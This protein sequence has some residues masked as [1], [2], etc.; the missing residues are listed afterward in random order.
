MTYSRGWRFGGAIYV[1]LIALLAVYSRAGNHPD[2]YFA[3]L[4]LTLPVGYLILFPIY[5]VAALADAALGYGPSGSSVSLAIAITGFVFAAT[6]NVIAF[7]LVV[8]AGSTYWS[9]RQRSSSAAA[10]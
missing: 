2:V 7:R 1:S 8:W 5:I 9:Q 10:S 6:I 3:M 4:I